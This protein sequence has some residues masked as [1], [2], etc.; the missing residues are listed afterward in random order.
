[1]KKSSVDEVQEKISRPDS[2]PTEWYEKAS[3]KGPGYIPVF[4][5]CQNNIH[6]LSIS[7]KSKLKINSAGCKRKRCPVQVHVEVFKISFCCVIKSLQ[8]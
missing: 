4:H 7:K 1:M 3:K 8:S 5:Q 2:I 6:G